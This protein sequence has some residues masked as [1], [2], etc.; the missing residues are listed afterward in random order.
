[1]NFYFLP[2]SINPAAA[3][4]VSFIEAVVKASAR[5]FLPNRTL[6]L[7]FIHHL[8]SYR[9]LPIFSNVFAVMTAQ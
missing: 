2:L 1:L 4:F 5:G 8:H 9:P 6:S 3:I 7:A